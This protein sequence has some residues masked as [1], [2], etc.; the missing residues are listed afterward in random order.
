MSPYSKKFWIETSYLRVLKLWSATFFIPMNML[1]LGS[2]Y[3]VFI[4][5]FRLYICVIKVVEYV[6]W[7]KTITIIVSENYR[8][9]PNV[10]V[11][12][13]ECHSKTWSRCL[14]WKQNPPA[15]KRRVTDLRAKASDNSSVQFS[16][17]ASVI[18]NERVVRFART[19]TLRFIF[20]IQRFIHSE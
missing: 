9:H 7:Y 8:T 2:T 20:E 15:R 6:L 12:L 13:H 3:M 1:R 4:S 17:R 10:Y 5:L 18:R 11:L 16:A 14:I 19:L